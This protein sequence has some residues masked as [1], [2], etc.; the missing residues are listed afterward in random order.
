M[1]RY[2]AS[3]RADADLIAA[4]LGAERAILKS[5]PA[6]SPARDD[7]DLRVRRL[8]VRHARA[9]DLVSRRVGWLERATDALNRLAPP[10]PPARRSR[11]TSAKPRRS[12]PTSAPAP[13]PDTAP[14]PAPAPEPATV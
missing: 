8:A 2:L 11:P 12:R 6:T 13:A 5:L 3:A 9:T 4:R 7:V 14:A 1:E 10:P